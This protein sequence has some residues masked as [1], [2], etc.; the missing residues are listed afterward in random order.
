[1]TQSVLPE[2]L[3][4]AL[5]PDY[6]IPLVLWFCHESSEENAGLSEVGAG[7]IGKLQWEQTL[8]AIVRQRNQPMT[9]ET[10]W[11]KICDF[12]NAAKPQRVQGKLKCEAVVADVL[13]K[14]CSLV[15]LVDVCSYSGEEL[16][17][18]NQFSACLV[19]SGV[20]GRKQT[21]DKARVAIAIPNG[22]PDATLTDTISLNQAALYCLS[23]DWNPLHL[24]PNFA[25]LAGFD[26]SILYGLCTFGFS[27]RH[28]L[29]AV[30]R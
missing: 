7:W 24:D 26:K 13:D 19:G 22:L 1:M 3:L 23:G 2:D 17:C 20:L 16:T 27:A 11:A 18:Y 25:S 10:S 21:T 28:V 9:P 4:E 12:D 8:G 29:T 5:K 14:G 30:G 6:V 15:L